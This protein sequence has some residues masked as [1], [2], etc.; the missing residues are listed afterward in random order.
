MTTREQKLQ[1]TLEW[2]INLYEDAINVADGD[3]CQNRCPVRDHD[4]NCPAEYLDEY[5]M[6]DGDIE[7]S[8]ERDYMA[9]RKLQVETYMEKAN[10]IRQFV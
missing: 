4:R 7:I 8:Y 1:K 2:L 10:D 9:C 6:P 5:E 3:Y